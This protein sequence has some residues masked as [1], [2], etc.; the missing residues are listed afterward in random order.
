MR[1]VRALG[2]RLLDV[3]VPTIEA[4]AQ[5]CFCQ[6]CGPGCDGIRPS[7]GL[8]QSC[9]PGRPCGPCRYFRCGICY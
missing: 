6:K 2:T 7:I 5:S 9:C 3:L 4:R 8:Q 1:T